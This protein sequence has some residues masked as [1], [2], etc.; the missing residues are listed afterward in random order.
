MHS[1]FDDWTWLLGVRDI[2][3][4]VKIGVSTLH[5]SDETFAIHHLGDEAQGA[6][7]DDDERYGKISATENVG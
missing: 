6:Q 3:A 4:D 1:S 7:V 5:A 2:T